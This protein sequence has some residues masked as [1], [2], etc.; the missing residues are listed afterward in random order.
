[1]R[2]VFIYGL[3]N[4]L[5]QEIFYVGKTFNLVKRLWNH[6]KNCENKQKYKIIQHIIENN[7]KPEILCLEK[8]SVENWKSRE[9]Y[10][11]AEMKKKYNLCNKTAGGDTPSIFNCT[12]VAKIDPTTNEILEK[13]DSIAE[14]TYKN[15]M[16]SPSRIIDSCSGKCCYS[17]NFIWR[18][19]DQNGNIIKTDSITNRR[20]AKINYKTMEIVKVYS[21]MNSSELL[22][23]Y[24]NTANI[25]KVCNGFNRMAYGYIW[26]YINDFGIIEPEQYNYN[27]KMINQYDKDG[28]FLNR[29]E[30]AREIE[31][32]LGFVPW[33]VVKACKNN[34]VYNN[35]LWKFNNF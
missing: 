24:K 21:Y 23:E 29:F 34:K 33:R 2:E 3:V 32:E 27:K 14:A 28:N 18:R 20:V 13:Y 1:M 12:K 9:I 35:F 4:P 26:R 16:K 6:I 17:H 5:T 7:K 31:R 22:K 25:S 15:N 30:N 10:W 19:L 8:C 11:I